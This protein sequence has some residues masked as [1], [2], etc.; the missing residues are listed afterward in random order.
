MTAKGVQAS[1]TD[2]FPTL[3]SKI[4]Q[5]YTGVDTSDATAIASDLVYLKTAYVKGQKIVGSYFEVRPGD[6]VLASSM[7][8]RYMYDTVWAKAKEISISK[9]GKYRVS[10]EHS[11]SYGGF[12]MYAQVYING[13][14]KG[15]AR[16]MHQLGSTIFTE[17]FILKANDKI[18][19]YAYTSNAGGPV[20]IRSFVV[21]IEDSIPTGTVILN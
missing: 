17:D 4:G 10:F 21:S 6:F 5:I 1:P 20:I 11:N 14:A 2:T 12:W 15:I 18:Q 9:A 19:V 3:A 16:S 8:S 7:G 13:N